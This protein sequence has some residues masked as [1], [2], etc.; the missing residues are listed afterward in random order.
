MGSTDNEASI[1]GLMGFD[2]KTL[3]SRF[4]VDLPALRPV[5]EAQGPIGDAELLRQVQTDFIFTAASQGLA[6]FA[7]KAGQRVYAYNFGYVPEAQRGKVAGAP[8]CADMAYLFGD[9]PA[10]TAADR[11][12]A[13]T[14]QDYLV[15]F[16]RTGDPNG[17]GLPAWPRFARPHP[18][19]LVVK[20]RIEADPD[21]RLR[22]MG[23]WFVKWSAETGRRGP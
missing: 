16:L 19:T 15:D 22:Q 1:F 18:A 6:R 7:A 23:P 10:P 9:E 14:M 13:Q 21:F 11:A 8:H 3:A 12:I 2:E 4:G 20:D 17:Q 5:Y